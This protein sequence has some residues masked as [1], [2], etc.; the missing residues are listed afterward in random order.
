M[1]PFSKTIAV[2]PVASQTMGSNQVYSTRDELLPVEG[3]LNPFRKLLVAPSIHATTAKMGIALLDDYYCSSQGLQL[4]KTDVG[5]SHLATY[6][7]PSS[8]LSTSRNTHRPVE[9]NL[10]FFQQRNF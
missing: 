9:P 3:S 2:Q 4:D 6:K 7:A 10:P 8:I 5:F 1:C